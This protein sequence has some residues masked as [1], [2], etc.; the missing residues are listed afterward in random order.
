L[1]VIP[2]ET[3]TDLAQRLRAANNAQLGS[4]GEFLFS[5]R[6]GSIARLSF[7][8]LSVIATRV[9]N[10]SRQGSQLRPAP[11]VRG[12]ASERTWVE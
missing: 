3:V 2:V 5:T 11:T 1:P 7:G 6:S 12:L 10:W 9:R 4:F 8:A